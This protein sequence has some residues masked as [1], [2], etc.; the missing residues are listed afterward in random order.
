V[1]AHFLPWHNVPVLG[2]LLLRGRCGHRIS[3]RYPLVEIATALLFVA[4]AARFG[5][6]AVLPAYL[7]LAAVAVALAMIDLDVRRRPNG[8]VLPS[9]VIG[10]LLLLPAAAVTGDWWSAGRGLVAV[11]AL[12]AGYLALALLYPS[13][14]RAG[15]G[16]AT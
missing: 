13:Y 6:A 10:A 3:L 1:A 7:Y 11:A 12:W 2:W 16:S 8:I 5:L 4:V 15:W 14:I 9:Y